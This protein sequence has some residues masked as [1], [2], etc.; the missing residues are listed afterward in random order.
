MTYKKIDLKTW[1][2]KEHFEGF[3]ESGTS[4]S[5]TTKLDVTL[6]YKRIKEKKLK[7]YPTFIHQVTQ[8]V[9][10][11][12]CFKIGFNENQELVLWGHMEANY[13]INSKVSDNFI[14][15]WTPWHKEV[16]NFQELY[17]ETLNQHETSKKMAPQV[18]MPL[19]LFVISMLPWISFDGFNLVFNNNETFLAPIITA[20]KMIEQQD[21][22]LLPVA[23]QVHH[24]TSDG[25]HV[26]LL[27]DKLQTQFNQF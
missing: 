23:I 2:R 9:N 14:S 11:F 20:G 26:A 5:I 24:A 7:F 27:V 13:T 8:V 16:S 12:D 18:D 21:K 15:V 17:L 6:F 4:F 3:M 1:E 19:N 10:E 25:Y 22:K